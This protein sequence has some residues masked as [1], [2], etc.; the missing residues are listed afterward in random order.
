[1]R[2]SMIAVLA[3]LSMSF[4]L[5]RHSVFAQSC[6]AAHSAFSKAR[7]FFAPQRI[8][9][10]E[11]AEERA[12]SISISEVYRLWCTP[13]RSNPDQRMA[14]VDT[15]VKRW[16]AVWYRDDPYDAAFHETSASDLLE[17]IGLTHEL[18]AQMV[19]D[20]AF[21]KDW[22]KACADTCFTIWGVPADPAEE[23]GLA[24]RLWLRNDLL[25][26]L[27]R[28]PASKPVIKMLVEARYRLIW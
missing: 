9:S 21:T 15:M 4:G 7:F 26:N 3:A 6:D 28:E 23:H 5:P 12:Y 1:M 11:S 8:G 18:P 22:V 25:D 27:K 10:E 19:S 14:A 13:N 17:L 20:P 24:M 2:K 16:K